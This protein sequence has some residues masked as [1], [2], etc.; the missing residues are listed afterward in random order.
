MNLF[1]FA[2]REQPC[3]LLYFG[4]GVDTELPAQAYG[5]HPNLRD[6]VSL[7]YDSLQ[8]RRTPVPIT[9][10]ELPMVRGGNST[11]VRADRLLQQVGPGTM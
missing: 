10:L 6:G 9:S 3:M 11:V 2:M 4:L 1:V 5:A 7:L 8:R